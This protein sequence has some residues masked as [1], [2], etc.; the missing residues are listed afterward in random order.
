MNECVSGNTGPDD[1]LGSLQFYMS[2]SVPMKQ[3]GPQRTGNLLKVTGLIS[4]KARIRSKTP[5]A[6][7]HVLPTGTC[8]WS[9]APRLFSVERAL[10]WPCPGRRCLARG[11]T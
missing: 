10:I 11:A 3:G 8:S 9:K 5:D 1:L 2:E 7:T 6:Q 4:G